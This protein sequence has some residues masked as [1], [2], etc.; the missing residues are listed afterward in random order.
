MFEN[1]RLKI[2]RANEHV[3]DLEARQAAFFASGA[4]LFSFVQDA[5]AAVAYFKFTQLKPIPPEFA[6]IAGDAIHNY[7]A[8]L[9]QL[10]WEIIG[11]LNPPSPKLVQFPFGEN[12]KS[13]ESVINT[14]QIQRAGKKVVQAIRDTKPYP[15]GNGE[16]YWLHELDILD[17]HK[18]VIGVQPLIAPGAFS[19]DRIETSFDLARLTEM[20]F[21]PTEDGKIG[22]VAYSPPI[23]KRRAKAIGAYETPLVEA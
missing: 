4:C 20:A 14:R 7:R 1:A 8:A 19:K 23:S 12:A 18:L 15:E 6:L 16:L 5:E 9:D 13:F 17:K 10:I 3:R 2:G 11:P 22:E 21:V